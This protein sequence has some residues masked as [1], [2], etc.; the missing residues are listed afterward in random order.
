MSMQSALAALNTAAPAVPQGSPSAITN[1]SNAGA[2]TNQEAPQGAQETKVIADNAQ[3][4]DGAKAEEGVVDAAP[5]TPEKTE[6]KKAD[7]SESSKQFAALAKKEKAIVKQQAEIKAKEATISAREAAISAKEAEIKQAESL[8]E[9]DVLRALEMKGYTYQKL[10]DMI[11][12]GKVA[13]DKAPEDPIQVAR[14]I[15]TKL[16]K[17]FAD[18]EAAKEESAKKAASEAAAR[19]EEE[20]AQAYEQYRTEVSSFT[21]EHEAEYELINMYGQQELIIDTVKQYY[22]TNKRVLSTKEASDMVENYLYDEA[23]KALNSKKFAAAKKT[24]ET[25]AEKIIAPATNK[26]KAAPTKTLSNNLTPTMSSVLP[27]ATDAERMKRAMAKLN[28]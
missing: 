3:Q 11:L 6:E 26:L 10:T 1:M 14:D 12:S 20:L 24:T 4:A 16:R 17:E 13:P 15:E 25:T 28:T 19:Q 23:Q 21:K 18:R 8:W 22:E 9:T 7:P 5:L 2:N 27:S